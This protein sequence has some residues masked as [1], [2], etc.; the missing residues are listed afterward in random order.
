MKIINNM[1]NLTNLVDAT[2]QVINKIEE[3]PLFCCDNCGD[4]FTRE[5]MDLVVEDA[6]LCKNCTYKSFNN[7]PY[8]K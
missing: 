6:D 5:E 3:E 2:K 1:K 7:A 4:K 8:G